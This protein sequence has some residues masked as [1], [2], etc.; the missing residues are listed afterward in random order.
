MSSS[1]CALLHLP[2]LYC[3]LPHYIVLLPSHSSYQGVTCTQQLLVLWCN[4]KTDLLNC[5]SNPVERVFTHYSPHCSYQICNSCP[6]FPFPCTECTTDCTW[7]INKTEI[8]SESWN[9]AKSWNPANSCSIL[10]YLF[11]LILSR[12][13]VFVIQCS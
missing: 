8:V 13:S 2:L 5:S 1:C 3:S 10:H 7:Q 6:V 12:A 11:W 4:I 9:P